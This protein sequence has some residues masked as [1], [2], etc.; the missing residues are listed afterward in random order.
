MIQ[1]VMTGSEPESIL[2]PSQSLSSV[3]SPPA[4]ACP[5]PSQNGIPMPQP[6]TSDVQPQMSTK[7]SLLTSANLISSTLDHSTRRVFQVGTEQF[8]KIISHK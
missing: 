4:P 6:A 2:R 3:P 1:Q 8:G 7:A 5:L